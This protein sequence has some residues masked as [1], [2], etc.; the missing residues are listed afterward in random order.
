MNRTELNYYFYFPK[1]TNLVINFSIQLFIEKQLNN[2]IKKMSDSEMLKYEV[3]DDLSESLDSDINEV[4]IKNNNDINLQNMKKENFGINNSRKNS[5]KKEKQLLNINSKRLEIDAN[6]NKIMQGNI[7]QTSMRNSFS[8]KNTDLRKKKNFGNSNF[9][10]NK[11]IY[12]NNYRNGN[13]NNNISTGK[14]NIFS[15]NGI[16]EKNINSTSMNNENNNTNKDHINNEFLGNVKIINHQNNFNTIENFETEG[17]LST[18]N[19]YAKI[20]KIFGNT[21]NN[22][23][24]INNS[25]MNNI[26]KSID[27]GKTKTITNNKTDY[28]TISSNIVNNSKNTLIN[29]NEKNSKFQVKLKDHFNTLK[30]NKS[31][32]VNI[33]TQKQSGTNKAMNYQNSINKENKNTP[34]SNIKFNKKTST[35]NNKLKNNK[36]NSYLNLKLNLEASNFSDAKEIQF[37]DGNLNIEYPQTTKNDANIKFLLSNKFKN[38]LDTSLR[39]N[40]NNKSSQKNITKTNNSASKKSLIIFDLNK[41]IENQR[42]LSIGERLYRKSVALQNLEKNRVSIELSKKNIDTISNCSFKPKISEDSIM[43]SIKVFYLQL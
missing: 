22:N 35:I 3:N 1:I 10:K 40:N 41:Q 15:K 19:K 23:N 43:L 21:N 7:V 29:A 8:A 32:P 12:L 31:I 16:K 2:K 24:T 36:T 17:F 28:K 6:L 30:N 5:N 20:F 27:V 13:K 37:N 14:N 18:K 39:N 25:A 9:N 38:S 34:S 26:K 4:Q 42:S 33:Q 11:N